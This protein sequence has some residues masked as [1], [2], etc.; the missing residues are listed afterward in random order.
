MFQSKEKPVIQIT[1]RGADTLPLDAIEE[2]QGNLKKRT[3]K[4]IENII[5]SIEKYGFSF[6]FYIWINEGRNKCLDGHGRIKALSEMRRKGTDLPLFPVVYVEAA[7]EAEAKQKLLRLNSQYGTMTIESVMEFIGQMDINTEEI[8]LPGISFEEEEE[9]E[10]PYTRKIITPTYE[11]KNEAPP[12]RELGD[13]TKCQELIGRINASNVSEEEKEFLRIAASRHI[14]FNY[15]KVA[16]YY[17]QAPKEVQALMEDSALV[18]ID[19][20]RAIEKGY[21]ILTKDIIG[22]Y[23]EDYNAK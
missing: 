3:K 23:S 16:D 6:P 19:F 9:K 17:A 4:D 7:D 8:N 13:I 15:Q 12:L 22:Q 10:E 2:F 14:V 20:E 11:P 21:V 1:C 5:A 18:I